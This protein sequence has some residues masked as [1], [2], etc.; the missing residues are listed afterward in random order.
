MHLQQKWGQP[1]TVTCFA[2]QASRHPFLKVYR[3]A[4]STISLSN[5]LGF[6]KADFKEV[7]SSNQQ[8][9][10]TVLW[11]HFPLL[12][13]QWKRAAE[14][15]THSM[16]LCA[17]KTSLTFFPACCLPSFILAFSLIIAATIHWHPFCTRHRIHILALSSIISRIPTCRQHSEGL[18]ANGR[19]PLPTKGKQKNWDFR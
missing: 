14:M 17:L 4:D 11:I 15:N 3:E 6:N 2:S 12:W 7:P 10:P 9:P 13:L 19:T 8:I 16:I 5:L 1:N 18:R